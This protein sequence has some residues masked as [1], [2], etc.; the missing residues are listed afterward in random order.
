MEIKPDFTSFKQNYDNGI[1]QVLWTAL[2]ADLDTPVSAFLKI[3]EG[4]PNTYLLESVEGGSV[5]GRYS[6]LGL[7]P[8]LI[9]RCFGDKAELNRRAMA[10]AD[11]FV[12]EAGAPLDSLKK[13]IAES[14]IELPDNLPPMSAGLVGYMGYDTVRLMEKLPDSNKDELDVP[15]GIFIRPTVTASFDTIED[16]VTVVTPVRP[17]SGI[18]ADAAYDL[19]CARLNDVVQ[20]FQRNLFIDRRSK[21]VPDT[22]PDPEVS[23]TE[24][25]F[26]DMVE[27]AKDYIRAGDIFQVVLSQRYTLPYQLP[28]FAFYRA[29]RRINPSPF[30]FY[31]DIGGFQVVGAS[32]EILVRLRDG[33]VTIRPIAGTR[34]RGKTPD[35]DKIMAQ[36]LLDDPKERSEHLMLLDLGRNDVGRVS[37]PGTVRVTDREQIEYYSHVMHIVSNVVGQIDETKY[38]AMDALKAGFPAGTVSGAP[39][40]RAMEII[41]ELE[42]VRRGIYAGCIGYISADGSMD[43]CIALRT[44]VIKDEKIHIQAGAGVVVDSKPELE[45][46]ECQNKAG[47]LMAAA[48]EAHRFA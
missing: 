26:H 10:D 24:A 36:D 23:V 41:D 15:D 5:R 40:V 14:Y 8:D 30:M 31:L 48:R 21:S 22:L 4:M 18:S 28:P 37:K 33:E 44:A 42:S 7:K 46:K 38:D 9:W 3:A 16:T 2:T 12:A 47:A 35:D 6:F 17:E 1:S 34:R 20:Q 11:A 39:K 45:H 19:A 43:T 29:L 13:L 27:K 25:G 32:P